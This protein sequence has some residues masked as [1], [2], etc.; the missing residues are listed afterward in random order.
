MSFSVCLS[1]H[2]HKLHTSAQF[3]T[4]VWLNNF[5]LKWKHT[6]L[7]HRLHATNYTTFIAVPLPR[8]DGGTNKPGFKKYLCHIL[9]L[10]VSKQEI[11]YFS[12]K[13][14]HFDFSAAQEPQF[15]RDNYRGQ[16]LFLQSLSEN[17][18]AWGDKRQVLRSGFALTDDVDRGS[19]TRAEMSVV[20]IKAMRCFHS[21]TRD[22]ETR[23]SV[24]ENWKYIYKL[25]QN[26][27]CLQLDAAAL[28]HKVKL[29]IRFHRLS[30]T[31][32]LSWSIIN[33]LLDL[34]L[35]LCGP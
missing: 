27:N 28:I 9:P 29:T 3:C 18:E 6:P 22:L 32:A 30:G 31:T 14:K 1:L 12:S 11:I 8:C 34:Y 24:A 17:P 25:K 13:P 16:C 7:I 21:L 26:R 4:E 10:L 15:Q 19:R 33:D 20:S 23:L 2:G 5:I 35:W